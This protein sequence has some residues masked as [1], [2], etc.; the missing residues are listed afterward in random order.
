[1]PDR[2]RI[3]DIDDLRRYIDHFNHRRYAQQIAYYAPD[4]RYR[5]GTL[6]ITSPQQIAEF[7]A[8]FHAHC[9]EHVAIADHAL[10]GDTLAVVLPTRF[11]PFRDY[12]RHDLRFHAGQPVEI[13]SFV[14][15]RLQQG[16]IRRIHVAR[17]SGSAAELRD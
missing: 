8:D 11:E 5:V 12:D 3:R 6:T 17:Y 2:A 16:K 13:V 10:S 15:Y 14:F 9:H 7:Y 1:M 4:V